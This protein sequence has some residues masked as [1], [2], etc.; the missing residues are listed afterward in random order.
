LGKVSNPRGS[1][2][3][4]LPLTRNSTKFLLA[5]MLSGNVVSWLFERESLLRNVQPEMIGHRVSLFLLNTVQSVHKQIHTHKETQGLRRRDYRRVTTPTT[6]ETE[7]PDLVVLTKCTQLCEGRKIGRVKKGIV[8]DNQTA[9]LH[10]LGDAGGQGGQRVATNI[11][12]R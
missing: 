1:A 2:V 4:W 5:A 7:Y 10:Q 12:K 8:I 6:H 11:Q 9:Q 3:N